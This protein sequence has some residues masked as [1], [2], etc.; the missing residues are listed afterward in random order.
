MMRHDS[1]AKRPRVN[2]VRDD[3]PHVPKPLEII[4]SI[5][6]AVTA[7]QRSEI[8][9][10]LFQIIKY[11]TTTR[12]CHSDP[13]F[14]MCLVES[15]IVN[16]LNLQLGFVLNR[17]GTSKE[18]IEQL[19]TAMDV[20]YRFCPDT[21]SDNFLRA[22]GKETFKL[23][24][25][26]VRRGVFL[27]VLSI[28][29]SCSSSQFGAW[30]L[31]QDTTFLESITEGLRQRSF[32]EESYLE[33]FGLLKNI[34]FYG[35]GDIRVRIVLQPGLLSSITS[36]VEMMLPEKGQERLSAI[37]RNLTL[38]SVTRAA[39]AQRGDV[40]TCIVRLS[41]Q[42]TL[43][44]KR[45]LLNALVSMTMDEDS[46]LLVIFHG[47]GMVLELLK[48]L[49]FEMDDTVRKRVAKILRLLARES[50]VQML[51]QD[52]KLMEMLSD[53]ALHDPSFEVR[54]EAAE[55][56]GKCAGLTKAT[57]NQHAAVLEALT[58][59]ATSPHVH[60]DSI[61]RAVKEQSCHPENR[62]YL[63][64]CDKLLDALAKIVV[65]PDISSTAKEYV[66][67]T[68]LDLSNDVNTRDA[69]VSQSTLNAMVHCA[70]SRDDRQSR[71]RELAVQTMVNLANHPGN[72]QVMAKQARLIQSLLQ[73]AATTSADT[74]KKEVKSVL[75]KLAAQL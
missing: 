29:H 67:T 37:L 15:G 30:L 11:D 48:F 40:L 68:F 66:C 62:L 34:S 43:Q 52:S 64:K 44:T 17:R 57:M 8:I 25:Q 54:S 39:L 33:A 70:E 49:F 24:S 59:L 61:A 75:L 50:S 21:T 18:E 58:R 9:E 16:A 1:P 53:R 55:A 41:H 46:C 38:S 31:A 60:P 69:I 13:R 32:C 2:N 23:L 63:A 14:F 19:C 36:S 71:V 51:V 7:S 45:N 74:L 47:E 4:S 28:W 10:S 42:A 6:Q 73:F 5:H 22:R 65:S 72:L 27:P 56:F 26:A 3:D 12:F 35:E 20:F